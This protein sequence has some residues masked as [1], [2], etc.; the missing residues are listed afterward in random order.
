[1]LHSDQ[2]FPDIPK[3]PGNRTGIHPASSKEKQCFSFRG[4]NS[5]VETAV[6]HFQ[7]VNTWAG[8]LHRPFYSQRAVSY[9]ERKSLF[10]VVMHLIDSR[11]PANSFP[12]SAA[13]KKK[14]KWAMFTS[15]WV[16]LISEAGW[17]KN[18]GWQTGV[19]SLRNLKAHGCCYYYL[20]KWTNSAAWAC[21]SFR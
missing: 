10:L 3:L 14:K 15:R 11:H 8:T 17:D 5:E 20:V 6:P 7:L 4:W 21:L 9:W 12:L 16:P 18:Q 2:N 13:K 19:K 1:M